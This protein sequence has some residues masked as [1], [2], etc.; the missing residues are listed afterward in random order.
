M[1]T[2][3]A[4]A[5]AALLGL[6]FMASIR[7]P[8]MS[9]FVVLLISNGGQLAAAVAASVGC[10]VAARRSSGH[11]R[12]AWWWLSAGTGCWAGGQVVWSY[13]EVVL[14][15]EV[16]FPSLAD[17]GFL[18]F[19]LL[20]AVGL[21]I[22]L[23]TQGDQLVA[24][25]RDLFDGAIIACSLLVISWV[26][27]LGSVVAA[28]AD[29]WFPLV[30]SLAYPVGDLILAT[31]VLLALARGD[32][33]ERAPLAVLALGLGGLAF[34]DSA[35]VYLTSIGAYSSA[36]LASSG[37]VFGFLFVAAAG[38][39]VRLDAEVPAAVPMLQ[40][41]H[42][43]APKPSL[44]RLAL[45]Y[46]PLVAAGITLC[47]SLLSAR[48]ARTVEL[49]L[50]VA[51]MTFVLTRQFLAMADNQRLLGALAEAHDQLEHQ[52]LHD[53]L[54]GLA[55]RV[56][57]AD[58]LDRALLRPDADVSVLFCDLDDFKVV[59]DRY[60]HEVG[61]DLLKLVARRLLDCV[62]VTDTVARLGGDEFA[63]L[64]ED[65]LDAV[66]VAD[67][68]V[69]NVHEP[70][71]VRG[72]T[73]HTSISVGIAHHKGVAIA[74]G[75][76]DRR[77]HPIDPTRRT[78]VVNADDIAATAAREATAALL[79]RTADTAMYAAKG[80]GKSRAVLADIVANQSLSG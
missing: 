64:I 23:G 68:I 15:R 48:D 66:R 79:L 9:D 36:D 54:T 22:W 72:R 25:T 34:A 70:L 10:A 55:N 6:V 17:V 76:D 69:A 61:D 11:R 13:Y 1:R 49:L 29:S 8:D 46:V 62:R 18:L 80:A 30:L 63:I 67:R 45:P 58:R 7:L 5:A 65:S 57:F 41:R 4:A 71:E 47:V 12:A 3:W 75:A 31:L 28:G 39:S 59:N 24:R 20:A 2:W 21:V 32:G 19:P 38:I 33:A 56:L 73:L 35:Y 50:A 27:T 14:D 78:R 16:P 40:P 77:D 37:W 74:A 53:S 52:A 43:D 26:T 60:G 42:H 44:L 51:L